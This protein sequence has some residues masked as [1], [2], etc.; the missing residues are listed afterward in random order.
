MFVSYIL[1]LLSFEFFMRELIGAQRGD[2][3][4]TEGMLGPFTMY[5]AGY[6]SILFAALGMSVRIGSLSPDM[7]AMALVLALVGLILR[8]KRTGGSTL[9]FVWFGVLSALCYLAKAALLSTVV[10]SFVTVLILLWSRSRILLRPAAIM[11]GCSALIAGPFVAGISRKEGKF[12]LGESGRL[13]YAWEISG[14]HRLIHWQREPSDIGTPKHPTSLVV[15]SPK[16]FTFAEPIVAT[17]PPW[18]SPSYWYDGIQAKVRFKRQLWVF[19][20]NASVAVYLLVRSPVLLPTVGLI[21]FTGIGSW[22][23]RI[24]GL[25]PALVPVIAGLAVYSLVFL[26]RRYV[27]PYLVI[28]W[29]SSLAAIRIRAK[30]LKTWAPR[31]IS[32]F[33]LIFV[34]GFARATLVG[35][36]KAAFQDLVH[37]RE[38]VPNLNYL[39]AQ[40]LRELGLHPGDKVGYIGAGINAEWARLDGVRVVAEVPLMYSRD[41]RLFDN[42]PIDDIG[43]IQAFW[44]A[45]PDIRNR[46]FEAFRRAG[47]KM[48]VTDGIFCRDLAAQWP[49]VFPVADTN[50][51]L[52]GYYQMNSRYL[53][54]LQ[55]P[56]EALHIP[57]NSHVSERHSNYR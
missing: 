1:A 6:C 17:Y 30:W 5:V 47:A 34:A 38:Q 39:L 26:E 24:T 44:K 9:T 51:K 21:L 4:D 57:G 18:Y 12:S 23:R 28:I 22:W 43:Q 41:E 8:I 20:V 50:P 55:T 31:A 54:L 10:I 19:I 15:T 35:S 53:D 40:R 2:P 11:I 56:V 3:T 45:A 27:N 36:L 32:I 52:S 42:Y 25:W 37:G 13:N 49:S 16:T 7:I 48:I 46:V 29:M 14:A 33:A